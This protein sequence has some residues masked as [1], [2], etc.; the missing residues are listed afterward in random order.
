MLKKVTVGF[1]GLLLSFGVLAQSPFGINYQGVARLS[2]GAPIVNQAVGL[3]MSITQGPNGTIEF[4]EDHRVI[5]NEF[6][7]FALVI[8]E[9]QSGDNLQDVN[10]AAGN[11]WLQIEL[12]PE[13]D[14]SFQL[15]GTQQLMSV[16]Y[17]LFS[18]QSADQ[19]AA[20]YGIS[21]ANGDITNTLPDQTVGLNGTGGIQITGTYPNF[22]VDGSGIQG[23]AGFGIDLASG[24]ITNT[25]PDQTVGLTGNGGIQVTGTYPNFTIDGS[26]MASKAY[27]DTGDAANTAAI[28]AEATARTTAD[29][30][31]DSKIT[32]N[33]ADIAALA[34]A[35]NY[36]FKGSFNFTN[37]T[38][39]L[40]TQDLPFSIDFAQDPSNFPGGNQFV[41]PEDG[42]YQI[43]VDVLV[44]DNSAIIAIISNSI[45]DNV[46]KILPF[47]STTLL[48]TKT[49]IYELV[50]GEVVSI[51]VENLLDG[52]LV[53]GEFTGH[54][55]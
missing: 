33:T 21:I 48:H 44:D 27:A 35:K 10:W 30:T 31:L 14:G 37:T 2:D 32:V 40:L 49:T 12:D 24:V 20:G 46:S 29:N 11:K 52:S 3:R 8:G 5:T 53:T 51:R 15:V 28:A 39:G 38:G 25:L 54:K 18:L 47:A 17:A 13:D 6:G 36:A 23:S 50:A 16:P 7:L 55:L 41:A 1:F 19:P 42:Y 22:T 4:S 43:T 9:G 34:A 45:P 26:A